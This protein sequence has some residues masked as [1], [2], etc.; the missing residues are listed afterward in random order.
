MNWSW[1]KGKVRVGGYEGS[2]EVD[3]G[4][5]SSELCSMI[6][7]EWREYIAHTAMTRIIKIFISN[8]KKKKICKENEENEKG[9][10]YSWCKRFN[11]TY[12]FQLNIYILIQYVS[13][14][15]LSLKWN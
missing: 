11:I 1:K 2:L 4:E 9:K 15:Q 7:T 12:N 3:D 5:V 10:K 6:R 13:N 14:K 8:L